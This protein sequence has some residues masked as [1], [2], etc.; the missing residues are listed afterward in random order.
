MNDKRA[1]VRIRLLLLGFGVLFA[2]TFARAAWIQVV[3][4]PSFEA[5]ASRQHR[6][7][8][9]IPAGRGTIFD[10]TGEP[11]AIGEQ[12]I[13]VYADP[14]NIVAPKKAAIKAA[15][16]LDLSA[17]ELYPKLRDRTK[18]FVYVDRKADALKAGELEKQHVSGLG[19]YPEERRT[20]PQ[21]RVAS[22]L[23]G[24]AGTDN[25]GLDGLE[26]LARQ[27]ARRAVRL[28][29]R[30]T[31]PRRP[32]DRRRQVAPRAAG[33]ERRP[34]DRPPDPGE[35]GAAPLGRRLA[36]RRKGR[37][38]DRDGPAHRRHPR[39]GERPDLRCERLRLGARR[40]APEP[41][42]HG[43]LRAGLDVQDRDDRRRA[44]GQRRHP[45]DVL[46][47]P[48]DDPRGRP[49]DPRL[50]LPPCR[51]DDRAADPLRVVERRHGD[52]REGAAR[53]TGARAVDR[54]LRLRQD[55]RQR[56]ARREPRHGAAVR[57]L[58]RLDDRHRA[59]RPGHRRDAAPD[60]RRL[61]RDRRT[62]ASCRSRT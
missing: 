6:E 38:G 30:R 26:K 53:R 36:L 50:A 33:Q 22:N 24:F 62:A 37:H 42:G 28:R 5:M 21:G 61:R 10:R 55:D 46:L 43:R 4:A 15:T 29:D 11:L 52:D 47:A 51:A 19:F 2:V 39:D 12:A 20:Y 40:P 17:D 8:I 23:L 59:D 25:F 7:T 3:R 31:R 32:G 35:R 27:D 14:R 56:A 49:R 34:H 44:R 58:V 1:N 9:E 57:R 13:T 18:Q 41:G 45:G 48:A 16:A 60:D 54:P